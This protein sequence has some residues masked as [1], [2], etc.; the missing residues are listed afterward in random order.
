MPKVYHIVIVISSNALNYITRKTY[1]TSSDSFDGHSNGCIYQKWI[2]FHS[3][4]GRTTWFAIR[5]LN[6]ILKVV[7]ISVE[8][9]K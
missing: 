9:I 1:K 5:L 2:I 8:D 3:L 7:K 6:Q 4:K